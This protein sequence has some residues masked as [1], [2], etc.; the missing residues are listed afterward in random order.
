M[1]YFTARTVK[2]NLH[3]AWPLAINALLMQSML[4]VDALLISPLGDVALAALG[5][6]TTLMAFCL[7]T[8]MA[9]ANGSQLLFSRAI[10][11]NNPAQLE[12]NFFSAWWINLASGVGFLVVMFAFGPWLVAQLTDDH[13]VARQALDYLNLGQYLLLF[14]A[15]TQV[16]LALF[17]AHGKTKLC[18]YGY[19]LEMPINAMASYL[20]IFGIGTGSGMGV[21]GA[22]L[23][24]LIAMALRALYL[25]WCCYRA[26]MIGAQSLFPKRH[27][28]VDHWAQI[29]HIAANVTLLAVGMSVYQLIYSQLA[30][31]AYV[32]ISLLFPWIRIGNQVGTAWAQA[33][34]I[35]LS[36]R[37]GAGRWR[38]L[39]LDTR[40]LLQ[41]A[42]WI[43]LLSIGFF[44]LLSEL[45]PLLYPE[46]NTATQGYL[47]ALAPLYTL[48]PLARVYNTSQGHILRALG[49]AKWV[50]RV[51]FIGQ[52][53]VALP[54]CALLVLYTEV[55]VFWAFA[56]FV[57]E[58]VLKIV[59]FIYLMR[60]AMHK[61]PS[62]L[63]M[64]HSR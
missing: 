15:L 43:A 33:S 3:I 27:S 9:L 7:G 51:H 17:N 54:L 34:A 59:P 46:L 50:F 36:Q 42:M 58:D 5:I 8:Q 49:Y 1:R 24:S 12:R 35:S 55:P 28:L 16:L 57:G 47:A 53:C 64:S 23:G 41:G 21:A 10:G 2:K 45:F 60:R 52:W 11:A 61:A 31:H 20:L 56:I 62:S 30:L 40:L 18:L 63:M 39:A 13:Q 19:L 6:A 48:L 38:S 37:L 26:K 29:Y 25:V 4:M 14:N 32:A 22:A 44:A